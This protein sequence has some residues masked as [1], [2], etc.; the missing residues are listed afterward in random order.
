MHSGISTDDGLNLAMSDKVKPLYES[1]V[2]F[3]TEEVDPVTPEY[4]QRGI[5][6]ADHW[7]YGEGQ[8]EILEG[9]KAKAKE[10]G[11]WNFF[12]PDAHTG[13]GLSNLDYAYIAAEL[14]KSPL[15]SESMNCSAPDTGNME[16]LERVGTPEQKARWLRPLL[17]GEIRSA[18]VMTEPDVASSDAKNLECRAE[19]DGDEWLINGDK[20]YISGAGDP[21]CKI[22]ICMLLTSPDGPPHRRHSQIL[23][24]ADTPGV[25][26]MEGMHVFGNDDAPHGH[27]HLRFENVRVP[28]ENMLLGEGRGFEISQM[29]LGPGRIHHCMRSI[30]A[31]ERALEMMVKRGLSREAFGKPLAR[32]GKNP[33]V[34]AQARIDIEMCRL[35]VLRAAKAMDTMGN[36]EARVWVSAVKATVPKIVCGIIDEAIQMHGA[37]GVS[38]WTPLSAM[39]ASQ[40]TLRLADGPDEV[41]WGVVGRFEIARHEGEPYTLSGRP[42]E[43]AF[44]GP[45]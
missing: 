40:R 10:R 11:L 5:G 42:R 31:A 25:R 37:T 39:Y 3:I 4:H 36:A 8:L 7:G 24:P 45:S 12:L 9:L 16:V 32:L 22:Y 23:V 38:Q 34:I 17:N 15:A 41:H 44:T 33:E 14:G 21:R 26:I 29:R 13:E 19:L 27:M 2:R 28:K 18:Y 30:G 20:Y 43:G 6:R 1:V 35:L